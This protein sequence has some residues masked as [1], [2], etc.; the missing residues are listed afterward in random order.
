MRPPASKIDAA[1]SQI[2]LRSCLNA[3][4]LTTLGFPDTLKHALRCLG[5][6][7][8]A[9]ERRACQHEK[10]SLQEYCPLR[11]A[12]VVI[13]TIVNARK[14]AAASP[15]QGAVR[16]FLRHCQASLMRCP[17]EPSETSCFPR[18]S[19]R[20]R[21]AHRGADTIRFFILTIQ[22]SKSTYNTRLSEPFWIP[23]VE[24]R[25]VHV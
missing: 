4:C 22:L 13:V 5:G 23:G 21:S 9:S 1:R 17:T 24:N 11:R 19:L 2:S 14:L 3:E 6:F 10:R 8:H 15:S 18:E 16:A 7:S 12:D 20:S 25:L